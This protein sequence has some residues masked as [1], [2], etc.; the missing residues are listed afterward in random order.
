M[1]PPTDEK[2]ATALGP[3]KPFAALDGRCLSSAENGTITV[4]DL[5]NADEVLEFLTNHPRAV[6]IAIKGNTLLAGRN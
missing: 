1:S 4:V 3:E 6:E 2:M 5:V